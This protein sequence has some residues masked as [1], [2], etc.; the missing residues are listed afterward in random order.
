[1]VSRLNTQ[2]KKLVV[3]VVSDAP[4]AVV[5]VPGLVI[6][7]RLEVDDC[8]IPEAGS[9][10]LPP[11]APS[12]T[13]IP[14]AATRRTAAPRRALADAPTLSRNRPVFIRSSPHAVARSQVMNRVGLSG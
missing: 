12:A 11:Q 5:E 7:D 8:A 14:T 4:V 13:T 1:M 3:L 6:A 2:S 9:P 10:A